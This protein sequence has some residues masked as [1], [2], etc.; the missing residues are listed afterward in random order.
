MNK[1]DDFKTVEKD[2]KDREPKSPLNNFR[3]VIDNLVMMATQDTF[4][5]D[6]LRDIKTDELTETDMVLY[7]E[8][9]GSRVTVSELDSRVNSGKEV[10]ESQKQFA[11][12]LRDQLI[13]SLRR[14]L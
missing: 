5:V 8:F 7:D 14:K 6:A 9:M 4:G 10:N 12:Y 11:L 1:F 2:L 13:E 3:G